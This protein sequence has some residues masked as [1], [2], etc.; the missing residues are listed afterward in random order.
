MSMFE[1]EEFKWRETYFV[2]FD[3]RQR[4]SLKQVEK[5][6]HSLSDRFELSGGTANDEGLF[7]SLSIHSPEDYAAIDVSFEAGEDVL[8]QGQA[9]YGELKSSALDDAEKSNLARLKELDGRFDLLHF[10]EVTGDGES[11]EMLD[12][13]AL[14]VVLQALVELTKGIGVDPQSGTLL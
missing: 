9:L 14:L 3:A 2:F 4:P 6:L 8:E 13:S 11:D 7:E 10:E 12:P 5:R 1:R